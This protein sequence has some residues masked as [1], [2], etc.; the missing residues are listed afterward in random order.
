LKS[1]LKKRKRSKKIYAKF[2]MFKNL[3]A[4]RKKQLF[5]VGEF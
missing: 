1:G 2:A 5:G 3:A 4:D